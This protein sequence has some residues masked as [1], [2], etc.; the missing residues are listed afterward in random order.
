MP[1][2][3]KERAVYM[4]ITYHPNFHKI[5]MDTDNYDFSEVT[6]P[7]IP[8]K[9]RRVKYASSAPVVDTNTDGSIKKDLTSP[10][11]TDTSDLEAKDS[12]TADSAPLNKRARKA[13]K[14]AAK[15]ESLANSK[16]KQK[17]KF[18]VW[19][20]NMRFSTTEEQLRAHLHKCGK[21]TRMLMQ[22]TPSMY[23]K[24]ERRNK[25]FA[26][27]D[28]ETE[29]EMNSAVA[30]SET[31][32]DGRA[33]LIKPAS[34]Y[35]T[36]GRPRQT[37]TASVVS[38]QSSMAQNPNNTKLF[39]GNLSFEC[40]KRDVCSLLQPLLS[41][42][43]DIQECRIGQFPDTGKCK[44]YAHVL[45]KDSK[46]AQAVL[47]AHTRSPLMIN[48]QAVRMEFGGV[49]ASKSSKK[50]RP[51]VTKDQAAATPPAQNTKTTFDE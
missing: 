29:D 19:I 6:A 10:A 31:W 12:E 8:R 44:G 23:N 33:L 22:T 2:P 37:T 26:F 42:P 11:P 30:L 46:S 21:I 24:S 43:G 39:M 16:K 41:G 32:L 1:A 36:S 7:T 40:T 14:Q 28:F 9:K 51:V 48:G 20:G 13:L 5:Q 35:S 49:S 45:F 38:M 3:T 34:D 50:S 47:M 25:G 17:T 4:V 27:V 15:K 18:G